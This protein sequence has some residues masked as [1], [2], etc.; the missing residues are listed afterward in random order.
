MLY[1]NKIKALTYLLQT[2]RKFI[3]YDS[4]ISIIDARN[5]FHIRM[6]FVSISDV[7]L[8]TDNDKDFDYNKFQEYKKV[9]DDIMRFYLNHTK[10]NDSEN[11]RCKLEK[12]FKNKALTE[13]DVLL[14]IKETKLL[15]SFKNF[16][17]AYN[18]LYKYARGIL[19][20]LLT[21]FHNAM[22]HIIVALSFNKNSVNCNDSVNYNIF[23]RNI[24]KACSHFK[25][26]TK[27]AYKIII[28]CMYPLI[29]SYSN[30]LP[31]FSDEFIEIRC[32]EI[33]NLSNM[34]KH[35]ETEDDIKNIALKYIEKLKI[36]KNLENKCTF[37]EQLKEHYLY[38][39]TI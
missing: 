32:K 18:D 21:E 5:F 3:F 27:D 26:G 2:Y 6:L 14:L 22:T 7:L 36:N 16:I 13:D 20:D 30:I 23:E 31:E 24:D 4:I 17:L 1:D 9:S 28:R 39:K 19:S 35:K 34:D 38:K 29:K 10:N 33:G 15:D 37:I 25:R 11:L 12:V 8:S